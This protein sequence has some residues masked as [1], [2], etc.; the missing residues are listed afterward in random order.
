MAS[1]NAIDLFDPE[2][3]REHTRAE[4]HAKYGSLKPRNP[5][6]PPTEYMQKAAAERHEKMRSALAEEAAL[7][8]AR[9]EERRKRDPTYR[10]D[11]VDVSTRDVLPFDASVDYYALLESSE[12][13]SAAELKQAYK[14][15]S[16]LL[17][18]DKQSGK[19]EAEAADAA[20]RF[21]AMVKAYE[22]VSDISTRR[23][24]DDARDNESAQRSA[25]VAVASACP[26]PPPTC[27]DCVVTLEQFFH[28]A[29]KR[30]SFRRTLYGSHA[31]VPYRTLR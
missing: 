16:I 24:Y 15:L 9:E 13:A 1:R 31:C 29:A 5:G 25:G 19:S 11:A 7:R 26:K 20:E 4:L 14:R 18:P 17:H 12:F 22:I 27:I 3:A 30:V 2:V 21:D 28:G 10:A 6:A 23:A 8:R